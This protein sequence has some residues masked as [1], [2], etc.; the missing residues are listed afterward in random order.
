ML[1]SFARVKAVNKKFCVTRIA[2]GLLK[3]FYWAAEVSGELA[4][5]SRLVNPGKT[6]DGN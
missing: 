5:F 1:E 4:R 6:N 3:A 2:A